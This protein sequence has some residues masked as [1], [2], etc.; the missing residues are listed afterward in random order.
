LEF[1]VSSDN[2]DDETT[3]TMEIVEKSSNSSR[4]VQ[5]IHTNIETQKI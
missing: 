2:L 3:T 1:D 5:S 4:F